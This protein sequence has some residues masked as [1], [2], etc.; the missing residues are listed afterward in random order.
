MCILVLSKGNKDK[1]EENNMHNYNDD[2]YQYTSGPNPGQFQPDLGNSILPTGRPG[3]SAGHTGYTESES[4][5]DPFSETSS[6]S[7]HSSRTSEGKRKGK[8]VTLTRTS[9]AA[10]IMVCVLL[11]SAF[12]FGG[13]MMAGSYFSPGSSAGEQNTTN[14]NTA[15][16]NLEDATGSSM[17]VKE[18]TAKAQDSVVE[19]KTEAVQADT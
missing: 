1:R 9:L 16:F 8:P 17:T 13:A 5:S 18:I 10:V 2:R 6:F 11:S 7:K 19:I 4:F 14:A 12:G 15:G 3:E